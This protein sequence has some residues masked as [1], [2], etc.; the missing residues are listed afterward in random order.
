MKIGPSAVE[1]IRAVSH[2]V[3]WKAKPTTSVMRVGSDTFGDPLFQKG[4]QN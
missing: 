4:L 3:G 2:P 1:M